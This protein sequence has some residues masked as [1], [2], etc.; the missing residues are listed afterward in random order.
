MR[1]CKF[2]GSPVTEQDSICPN[3]SRE[4]HSTSQ[5]KQQDDGASGRMRKRH[6]LLCI[7]PIVCAI[8]VFALNSGKCKFG[9]CK[10]K[11]IEG[12]NYCYA[13][14]CALS[15]CKEERFGYSNYC[16]SHYLVYDDDASETYNPVYPY[17]LKISNITISSNSSYT[18]A[19]GTITNNSDQTVKFVEIKGAFET[20]S[21]SVV[22]TDW[23]YAVGSEGLAP[24]E[25]SKWRMSVSKDTK[26]KNCT[27]TVIDFDY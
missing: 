6:L 16:Y 8:V 3:C 23:T 5:Q 15:S 19:E 21:G 20:A 1:F 2:C 17:E 12:S 10:N 11:A 4:L 24:G 25:S 22:D 13:H 9:G 14:K 27:V 18:V 7:V 26:I